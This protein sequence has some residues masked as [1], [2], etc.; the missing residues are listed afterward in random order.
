MTNTATTTTRPAFST[1]AADSLDGDVLAAFTLHSA[2]GV[3]TVTVVNVAAGRTEVR[4]DGELATLSVPGGSDAVFT[5]A[6]NAMAFALARTG[7]DQ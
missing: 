3:E 1:L 6:A 7:W 5:D 4:V 2:D